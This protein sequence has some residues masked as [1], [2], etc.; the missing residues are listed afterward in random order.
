MFLVDIPHEQDPEAYKILFPL[1]LLLL[2]AK[3]FALLLD[4][5]KIP[6][7]IGYLL[8]GLF[9]GLIYLIPGQ[10]VLT[11]YTVNGLQFFSKI[12]VI[13]IM[14][15]A[16]AET[17]MKKVRSV[18]LPA[19]FIALFGVITPML[20]GWLLLYVFD[21]I[22]GNP[23]NP[24]SEIYYGVILSAT[25]VSITVA[26]L[27]EMGRLDTKVGS[28]LTSAAIIDDVMGIVVLSLVI[29]LGG[30]KKTGNDI[31]TLIM[32][33]MPENL[34]SNAGL[35][36]FF[37]LLFMS[38]F[39]ALSF[40]VGFLLRK[41]FNYLGTKYPHHVRIVIFSLA[42]CFL[43][44]YLAE[45]FNIADI[46]GAY[47]MGIIFSG[48]KAKEYIDHRAETTANYI[49]SP[50]FFAVIALGMYQTSFDIHDR[51]AVNFMI[52]GFLWVLIGLIGKIIGCYTAARI[53]RFSRM[54]SIRVGFGM[55]ARAEVLIV[56][57]QTGVNAGLVSPSILPFALLL[58][59]VSS[60]LTPIFLK[61][62]YRNEPTRMLSKE[63]SSVSEASNPSSQ[64]K[65]K[66]KE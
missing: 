58:I 48:T 43:W 25:S 35:S 33:A 51:T 3:A 57:A 23:I 11:D 12:G 29:S 59:L 27:K 1:G 28:A 66:S 63:P 22:Q 19:F 56:T 6:K 39:F 37:I 45:F 8:S 62:F 52:M 24:Y 16:G 65:T 32:N 14:F 9:V 40:L 53:F 60:F 49:F 61:L 4:K 5:I 38:I 64:E 18:G 34:Q 46:T 20:L 15:S 42:F 55:M 44:S 7:V 10:N 31:P 41:F 26:T 30:E 13:L 50:V 54:D 36:I 17:D 2:F 47:I 21:R